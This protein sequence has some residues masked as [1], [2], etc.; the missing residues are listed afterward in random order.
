MREK[1]QPW[2]HDNGRK[3]KE[4]EK[5]RREKKRFT[6][7]TLRLRTPVAFSGEGRKGKGNM[8]LPY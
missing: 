5:K 3:R 2:I 1:K 7:I 6:Y 4:C 8:T